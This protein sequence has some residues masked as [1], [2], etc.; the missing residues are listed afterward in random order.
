MS[1]LLKSR[2]SKAPLLFRT[3]MREEKYEGLTQKSE[4]DA[5]TAPG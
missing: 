1:V 2:F 5:A 4:L 3:L